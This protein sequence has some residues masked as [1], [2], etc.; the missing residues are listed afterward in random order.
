MGYARSPNC[1]KAIT[2]KSLGRLD[3]GGGGEGHSAEWPEEEQCCC[4]PGMRKEAGNAREERSMSSEAAC[5]VTVSMA[6][7]APSAA[8]VLLESPIKDKLSLPVGD[9]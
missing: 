9:F 6:W 7:T 8:V 3:W 4:D 2:V 5:V 1:V